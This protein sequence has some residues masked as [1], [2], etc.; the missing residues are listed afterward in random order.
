MHSGRFWDLLVSESDTSAVQDLL[1]WLADHFVGLVPV[2][3]SCIKSLG[4]L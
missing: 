2:E 3:K 1:Q 4:E